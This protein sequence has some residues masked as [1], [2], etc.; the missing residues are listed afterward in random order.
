MRPTTSTPVTAEEPRQPLIPKPIEPYKPEETFD[1]PAFPKPI[2]HS[3]KISPSSIPN[4]NPSVITNKPVETGY[5]NFGGYL[6]SIPG[7]SAFQP[8]SYP[9]VV[10]PNPAPI[11]PEPPPQDFTPYPPLIAK[12][13]EEEKP[14]DEAK[15]TPKQQDFEEQF[16]PEIIPAVS[17]TDVKLESKMNITS[18]AQGS[19]ATVTIPTQ[20]NKDVKKKPERF[21]LKT[22]IPI[23]KIDMKCVASEVSTQSSKKPVFNPAFQKEERPRVEIQSNIVI[24]SA[25]KEAESKDKAVV[26]T[27]SNSISTLINAAEAINK[28]DGQFRVPEP[29]VDVPIE[30]NESRSPSPPQ[31]AVIPRPIF[32]P[33]T[34]ETTKSN[35]PNKPPEGG[36]NE[37][38][39]Q[40]VFIQKKNNTNS[41]MVVT[42]QQQNPQVLLQRTNF[43]SKNLQAPSRLSNQKKSKD[44]VVTDNGASK[45]VSLKRLHQ[46]DCDENDF[47][48]LITEN[49]IYGNKI[50]VKEKSQGTQQEQ[51]LKNKTKVDKET[52]PEPK[53]VVLQP[54]YVYLSNVQFPNLL[55]I[56]NNS[57]LS[58]TEPNKLKIQNEVKTTEV[59]TVSRNT[60]PVNTTTD[61]STTVKNLKPC[62]STKEIHILKTSNNVLQA[63]TN[64]N[65]KEIILPNKKVVVHPQ[66]IH[67]I[68]DDNKNQITKNEDTVKLVTQKKEQPKPI[69]T[70]NDKVIIAC[71]YQKEIK[72]QPKIVL[73]LKP[74]TI[75]EVEDI[76][77]LDIYEKRKRLRRLKYLT[78]VN[79]DSPKIESKKD[80]IVNTKN[81]IT[82]DK[83]KAEIFKEF[84][85]TKGIEEINSDSDDYGENEL[86]EYNSIIEQ[87]KTKVDD[88]KKKVEFLAGFSLATHAAYKGKIDIREYIKYVA[89][90]TN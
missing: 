31:P 10:Q 59:A 13:P 64:N 90:G 36:F 41:K 48:N 80:K 65:N 53:N 46:D 1:K 12:D 82:P 78:N 89:I 26:T 86:R 28:S 71:P 40:I 37:Q 56:K 84:I 17:N 79:K 88:Q 29:K 25:S 14:P 8:V 60:S 24:K 57:K 43:E 68:V 45:V 69:D 20:T 76:S 52:Q 2:P 39:N 23:S 50:V 35:F 11:R 49:Q 81:I 33:M 75:T 6:Y 63:L 7:Y 5:P 34:I 15:D 70:K 32:N 66:M 55:M 51:D 72:I 9:S 58:Q 54:N 22:S 87:Y 21:S 19:G 61:T 62:I 83:M 74:K 3:P 4:P 42:I 30:T 85:K 16:T 44:E 27:Q 38:K 73:D 47:E 77:T 67:K 18:L